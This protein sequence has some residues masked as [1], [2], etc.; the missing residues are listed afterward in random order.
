MP[1]RRVYGNPLVRHVAG[2]VA[3]Q[4]GPLIYCLEEADNGSELHNL[5]LPAT[6]TFHER[7]G[8]GIF[9]RQ[10]LIQAE[11]WR[12]ASPQPESR[13]L[14]QYDRS[15]AQATPQTLT[16]IPWFS[17]ANRGEGEMRVWIDECR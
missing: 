11:G 17:W 8:K 6:S 5:Q 15:P 7:E 16:F 1:V 4:R 13:P 2:K 10:V 9:A 12:Q 3:I 14:W